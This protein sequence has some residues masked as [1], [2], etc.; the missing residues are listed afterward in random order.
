MK[1]V[2]DLL[3][4]NKQNIT[5]LYLLYYSLQQIIPKEN[6]HFMYPDNF[7]DKQKTPFIQYLF[8]IKN[9]EKN[10]GYLLDKD[11]CNN[12]YYKNDFS[13]IV[14]KN[15]EIYFYKKKTLKS[16]DF[17]WIGLYVNNIEDINISENIIVSF[18]IKI[19]KDFV[20]HD[21]NNDDNDDN[22]D[23]NNNDTD[24]HYGLKIHEPLLYMNHWFQECIK[25]IYIHI[26][27]KTKINKKN[28]YIILNFDNYMDEVEFYIK[29]FKIIFEYL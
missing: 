3:Y 12:I 22:D 13:K 7:T 16:E 20:F 18:D 9:T 21:S 6:F 8:D 23:N 15:N 14:K 29:N 28:Q 10:K 4:D 26:N 24:N 17:Q 11:Y 5:I 27:I 19:C 1:N 25:D 2:Y